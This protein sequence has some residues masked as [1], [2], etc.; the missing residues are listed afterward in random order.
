MKH[1][2]TLLSGFLLCS[3]A[4]AQITVT[5]SHTVGAGTQLIYGNDQNEYRLPV[6]GTNK[7]WDFHNLQD[8]YRDTFHFGQP[9]KAPGHSN[10]PNANLT[11]VYVPSP[12]YINYVN[13]SD[14]SFSYIG[15]YNAN[16]SSIQQD[17]YVLIYFPASYNSSHVSKVEE[18]TD[19]YPIKTDPD[20]GGPLPYIDSLEVKTFAVNAQLTDGW[21]TLKLPIGDFQALKYTTSD[22]NQPVARILASGNWLNAPDT[23]YELFSNKIGPIDTSY[24]VD[25]WTNDANIGFPLLSYSYDAGDTF[26]S[27]FSFLA[28]HAPYSGINPLHINTSFIYPNPAGQTLKINTRSVN[29][30][31]FMYDIKGQLVLVQ[32]LNKDSDIAVGHFARG[33]Y[34]LKLVDNASGAVTGI[35]K[36]I[37][38]NP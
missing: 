8:D 30:S 27:E 4:R 35:Q 28:S 13:V 33:V 10:F 22:F 7:V 24:V 15:T 23:I 12:Y 14:S 19:V 20:G 21:G 25:F 34:T 5:H 38:A 31:I 17:A 37:L 32:D 29:T 18:S 1:Y 9:S 36:V 6:S 2:V 3:A 16:D 11:Q 26:S